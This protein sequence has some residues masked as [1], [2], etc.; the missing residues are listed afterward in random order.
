MN[1]VNDRILNLRHAFNL[2]EGINPNERN[3]PGRLVGQPPQ[4]QG[5]LAGKSIDADAKTAAFLA[6]R[7]WDPISFKPSK[8]KLLQLGLDDVAEDLY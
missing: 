4:T 2:R 3:M 7:D 5:P 6:E 8:E 1:V